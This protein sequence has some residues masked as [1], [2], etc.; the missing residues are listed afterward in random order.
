MGYEDDAPRLSEIGRVLLSLDRKLDDFRAEVRAQLNDKL[1]R[2]IYLAEKQAL[3]DKIAGLNEKVVALEAGAR[4][5][6]NRIYGGISAVIVGAIL[7][8]IGTR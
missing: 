5:T 4:A 3:L 1:S 6:N 7:A 2:E 8:Y